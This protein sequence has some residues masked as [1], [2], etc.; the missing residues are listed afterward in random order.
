MLGDSVI[1][2]R[3]KGFSYSYKYIKPL[4]FHFF[5]S[6]PNTYMYIHVC[7]DGCISKYLCKNYYANN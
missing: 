2:A 3:I 1:R 6:K 4:F 5:S 7:I